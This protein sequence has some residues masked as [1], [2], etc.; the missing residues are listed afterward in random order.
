MYMYPWCNLKRIKI[1]MERCDVYTTGEGDGRCSCHLDHREG[2]VA[3]G[4]VA[5]R[6]IYRKLFVYVDKLIR[7]FNLI[8]V[9]LN[10]KIIT[11]VKIVY[12]NIHLNYWDFILY[13]YNN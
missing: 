8:L 13:Y 1:F 9:G 5:K 3:E 10:I 11:K 6:W 12:Q 2:V 7:V 4:W